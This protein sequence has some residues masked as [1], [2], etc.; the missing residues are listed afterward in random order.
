MTGED[1]SALSDEG[2]GA[3]G[4]GGLLADRFLLQARIGR[5]GIGDVWLAQDT[6]LENELVACK[7]LKQ[8]LFHDRRAVSDL[9]REVLLT[10]R[11]RHPHI[12]AVYTFWETGKARFITMEYVEGQNLADAL[13]DGGRAFAPAEV[14]GWVNALTNAL[15]Y[16]HEQGVL[17]RDVK[18]GNVLLDQSGRAHLA[19]F[20]IARTARELSTRLTGEM[21]CGTLLYVSPEQLMGEA[22]DRRSDLYSLAATV[23]E[24]LAGTPPF[25]QGAIVTQ[26]QMKAA[27]PIS[28][29]GAELNAVLLKGLEKQ[30]DRRYASCGAFSA[31]FAQAVRAGAE[32]TA[33]AKVES[34]PSAH[35]DTVILGTRDPAAH[36][37]R[38]GTVLVEAEVLTAQQL[39][40]ALAVQADTGERL[41]EVL[42]RRGFTTEERIAWALGRQ[43][44]LPFTELDDEPVDTGT[45]RRVDRN[46]AASRR[47]VVLR[48]E[49]GRLVV[50]MADPLDLSTINELEAT[51]G[52]Q[53]EIRVATGQAIARALDRA[54]GPG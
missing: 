32:T 44:R 41:G 42:V 52:S 13:L 28:H 33:R 7:V 5:G 38:L 29:L 9:K 12:L 2:S 18:P 54:Y 40:Q 43:F 37:K 26:I 6:H 10:R 14:A 49:A 35:E 1:K 34:R 15:D 21:T 50:A 48:E 11:L 20:G 30:P 19:D 17:H 25:H 3:I 47:Y 27:P 36:H 23:Y 51:F 53:A 22:L 46:H 39:S 31:A 16:A 24:L 45:A 4:T 8:A